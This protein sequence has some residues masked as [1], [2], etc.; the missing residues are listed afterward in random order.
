M[1]RIF[2]YVLTIF[3]I[4]EILVER[5]DIQLNSKYDLNDHTSNI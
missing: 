1:F 5:M 2:T 4:I 3:L